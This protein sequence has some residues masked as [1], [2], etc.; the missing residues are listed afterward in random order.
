MRHRTKT[1][2]TATRAS[3]IVVLFAALLPTSTRAA[4]VPTKPAAPQPAAI[5]SK[6]ATLKVASGSVDFLAVGKPGFLK[7]KGKGAQ[8]SGTLT[9]DGGKAKGEFTFDLTSLDTENETR[10]GH[11]KDKYLEVA[12]FPTATITFSDVAAKEDSVSTTIPAKLT[13]HGQTHAVDMKS[14]LTKTA[15]GRQAKGEFKFKLSEYGIDIPTHLTV[16]IA[17]E[18]TVN[19]NA[20]LK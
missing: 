9:F 1:F 5:A 16:T 13:L 15:D 2:N 3:A 17:D 20:L 6:A 11:M 10:N 8:P 12:K 7:V 18:V 4:E 19:I 14:E